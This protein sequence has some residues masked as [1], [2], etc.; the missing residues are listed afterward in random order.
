MRIDVRQ[1]FSAGHAKRLPGQVGRWSLKA[2]W[3]GLALI[4]FLHLTRGT[5]IRHV[6]GI[7]D[8]EGPIAVNEPQFPLKATML[9]GASLAPGNRVD[10]ALNGDGTYPRLWN[11]LRSAARSITLQV[12]YGGLGRMAREVDGILRDRAA[13]GVRVRVLYDAFGASGIPSGEL[14][15]LRSAGVLVAPFRPIR[16]A[17]LHLAQHR[18]H[19]RGIVI[20]DRIAWTG[21]FG[22]DDKWFGDGRTNGSWRETNVRFEGPAVQQLQAAFTAAWSEATGILVTGRPTLRPQE[23]G[24]K[25]A[26]LLYTAP[27]MG[28]T[29]AER[30]LA[31]SIAGARQTLYI[32]NSYFAPGRSFIDLLSGAARRGVDV[33]ILTAG[34]QTDVQVVRSAGRGWYDMLLTAGV[35]IYEWQPTTLHSKTFVVDGAWTTIGSMNFDNRSL[36]LNDEATLMVLDP[37]IGQQMNQVFLDDLRHSEEITLAAFRQRS[38]LERISERAA[39][40]IERL[41]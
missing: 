25:L 3:G 39:N 33:R 8:D 38:W 28:S 41:L 10:I 21:G 2:A 16:L 4:G 7:G 13:A 26:G 17:T 36:A 34:P 30:F 40:L 35:R 27:T 5:A 1:L 6:S 15:A 29:A 11:D 24:A 19:I 12:Y 22:I 18:S 14:D 23:D 37:A 32:T 9:T 20:D 31:L